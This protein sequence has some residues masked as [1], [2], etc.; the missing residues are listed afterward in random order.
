MKAKQFNKLFFLQTL[1][2]VIANTLI[3]ERQTLRKG[4]SDVVQSV[5]LRK[6]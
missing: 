5:D 3:C 1:N 2:S 4:T 6:F